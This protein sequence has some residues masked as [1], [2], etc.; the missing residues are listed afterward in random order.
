MKFKYFRNAMGVEL[1]PGD[2][3]FCKKNVVYVEP[4]R[5]DYKKLFPKAVLD[6]YV[7]GTAESIPFTE[8]SF[9][10]IFSSHVLEHCCDVIKVLKEFIRVLKPGGLVILILPHMDRMFDKGRIPSTLEKHINDYSI[11]ITPNDYILPQSIHSDLY[12]DFLRISIEP[13]DHKWKKIAL[14]KDSKFDPVWM[15][16]NNLVH[17]HCWTPLEIVKILEF[18]DL[19]VTFFLNKI[20]GRSDSFFVVAKK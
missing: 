3:P 10:F 15:V 19:K 13:Y 18:L 9:D 11:G 4:I 1:G 8:N 5:H 14:K 6:K 2:R 20:P 16:E 7:N 17:F 12:D